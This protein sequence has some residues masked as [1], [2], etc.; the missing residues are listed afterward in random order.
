MECKKHSTGRCGR[1]PVSFQ[2]HDRTLF[3][4][5]G[6]F[7]CSFAARFDDSAVFQVVKLRSY[8]DGGICGRRGT[9]TAA[10]CVQASA[11]GWSVNS[12]QQLVSAACTAGGEPQSRGRVLSHFTAGI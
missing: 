3:F 2:G 12:K 9:Q 4:F 1:F 10:R 6:V 8:G 5:H 7:V 11:A